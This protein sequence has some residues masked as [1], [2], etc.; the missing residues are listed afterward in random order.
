MS[1]S[2]LILFNMHPFYSNYNVMKN[3]LTYTCIFLSSE[4]VGPTSDMR[5][6]RRQKARRCLLFQPKRYM[7]FKNCLTFN[8]RQ[9]VSII[10][11][12]SQKKDHGLKLLYAAIVNDFFSSMGAVLY[13][14][15][16]FKFFKTNCH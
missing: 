1:R 5:N 12:L 8:Q 7:Y 13:C 11:F 10:V 14:L 4:K 16:F 6:N 3:Y 9:I 2:T 15:Q